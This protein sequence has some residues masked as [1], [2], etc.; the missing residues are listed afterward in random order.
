MPPAPSSPPPVSP[1]LRAPRRPCIRPAPGT[2]SLMPLPA[3]RW[4]QRSPSRLRAPARAAFRTQISPACTSLFS[5]LWASPLPV[6]I[7]T[8]ATAFSHPPVS[9]SPPVSRPLPVA[10]PRDRL[11]PRCPRGAPLPAPAPPPGQSLPA[12]PPIAPPAR[13]RPLPSPVEEG[14]PL[15]LWTHC[16][17]RGRRCDSSAAGETLAALW[18]PGPPLAPALGSPRPPRTPQQPAAP[19]PAT[20]GR[21]GALPR[22]THLGRRAPSAPFNTQRRGPAARALPPPG[23][24]GTSVR[25]SGA[26]PAPQ[27]PHPFQPSGLPAPCPSDPTPLS[28]FLAAPK[29][30]PPPR[31]CPSLP[32][33]APRVHRPLVAPVPAP[34]YIPAPAPAGGPAR[35]PAAVAW[36]PLSMPQRRAAPRR[37]PAPSP[38]LR[39]APRSNG[40]RTCRARA[41]PSASAPLGARAPWGRSQSRTALSTEGG[42]GPRWPPPSLSPSITACASPV[43]RRR[44]WPAAQA[45][46]RQWRPRAGK[47]PS[48]T[49][50]EFILRLA[51]NIPA[52]GRALGAAACGCLRAMARAGAR[53]G[54]WAAASRRT[55]G[56]RAA[57]RVGKPCGLAPSGPTP[58]EALN[59]ADPNCRRWRTP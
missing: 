19:A 35:G 39:H 2:Q 59:C 7:C 44:H 28:A 57:G 31:H 37:G 8:A 52:A 38:F 55:A 51:G 18:A 20:R 29:Q 1:P 3:Q 42:P 11:T 17:R 27:S 16:N 54:R 49:V 41:P 32:S 33:L 34:E 43:R 14:S 21:L 47:A 45:A 26:D 5:P 56:G 50:L 10:P 48:H 46:R 53:C 30:A 25:Q 58:L 23:T 22:A 9:P 36:R 24:A 40:A 15:P 12:A 13:C 6:Q 4:P